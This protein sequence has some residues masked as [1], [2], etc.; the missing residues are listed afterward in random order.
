MLWIMDE[1]LADVCARTATEVLGAS[2]NRVGRA[3]RRAKLYRT[4]ERVPYQRIAFDGGAVEI[5]SDGK[6]LVVHGIHPG[7]GQPY[8]W[9]RGVPR[10]VDLPEVSAAQVAAYMAKLAERL[11][12]A[13]VEV[14]TLA[15]D[16]HTSPEQL[17]GKVE[18]VQR[19][20]T[21]LP[22]T[23]E[24]FRT[25]GKYVEVAQAIKGALPDDPQTGLELFQQWA[26]KYTGPPEKAPTPERAAADW[27]RTK[28]SHS[29]GAQWLYA[30]A[31]AYGAGDFTEAETWFE[32]A[33]AARRQ[34]V[35]AAVGRDGR[36][37]DT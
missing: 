8:T 17:V 16:R 18:D 24:L 2:E 10:Y 33:P 12:A 32:A 14:S 22:N 7:T 5:L 21:A 1:K 36:T 4:S 23:Y 28:P 25:Y 26:A 27:A 11:P 9:P 15:A 20:I 34:P 31:A 19:A 29:L 6:Q 3:P 30:K 35:V 13:K 37:A